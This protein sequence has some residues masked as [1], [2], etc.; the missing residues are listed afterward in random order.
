MADLFPRSAT[1]DDAWVT[2]NRMGPNVLWLA[3][4]LT[5]EM[6]LE[7]GMRVMDLG[8]GKALSSV[9]LA[10]EFGVEVWATDLWIKPTGN[11]ERVREAGL[12]G[13]VHPIYAEAHQL[14]Y[15][16]GFFDAIISL[17]AYQ[18][19]GTADLYLEYLSGFLRQDGEIGIVCPGYRRELTV[20]TAPDYLA[21]VYSPGGWYAFHSPDW[22][23]EHWAKAGVVEVTC[24]DEP[25]EANAI[26]E[27][28]IGHT[29]PEEHPP[30]LADFAAEERLLTF[31]GWSGANARDDDGGGRGPLGFAPC[32]STKTSS[33][34]SGIAT[35]SSP[36]TVPRR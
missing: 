33:P 19:F 13:R 28:F 25:P 5:Q 32:L 22:W 29:Q 31:A 12:E 11:W 3:E 16:E 26:W 20:E 1:Y 6:R 8:C 34:T 21:P 2:A 9:F 23:R 14:P 18:Y 24:A 27:E 30:M 7:P 36:S 17:D 35:R 4:S 10:Q 15:A